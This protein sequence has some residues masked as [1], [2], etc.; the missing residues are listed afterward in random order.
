MDIIKSNIRLIFT[1]KAE[2]YIYNCIITKVQLQLLNT[3]LTFSLT[4]CRA[5][6]CYANLR[7]IDSNLSLP[8][9]EYIL[10]FLFSFRALLLYELTLGVRWNPMPAVLQKLTSFQPIRLLIVITYFAE[11]YVY[12][13]GQLKSRCRH[14]FSQLLSPLVSSNSAY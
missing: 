7:S 4:N 9:L 1:K 13:H 5:L 8:A 2:N 10:D 14:R 3:H 11:C 6:S 12:R